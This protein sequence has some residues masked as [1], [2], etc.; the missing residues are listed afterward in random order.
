[1]KNYTNTHFIDKVVSA[2]RKAAVE[3]EEFQAKASLGKTEALDK[4]EQVKK[5]FNLV[6]H[7]SKFKLKEGK[8]KIDDV[9]AK[10]DELRVQLALGRTETVEA[11]KEQKKQLLLT[12]HELEV[13]IKTNETL[14]DMYA[15]VLIEIEK[16]KVQL[17]VLEHRIDE[18]KGET[19]T[20]FEKGKQKFSDFIDGIKEKYTKKEETKWVHFQSEI[21]E[22]FVHFKQAFTNA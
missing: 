9:N 17:E 18:S 20:S 1:M 21:A 13:K 19:T 12:L 22:A 15:L 10:F 3:L 11:F 8:E 16:F 4:Y 14:N 7:E 2:L 5:K 6:I